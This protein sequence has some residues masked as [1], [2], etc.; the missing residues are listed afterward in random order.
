MFALFNR[1]FWNPTPINYAL[2]LSNLSLCFR[3]LWSA[4]DNQTEKKTI[5][6]VRLSHIFISNLDL[7]CVV[8]VYKIFCNA[9]ITWKFQVYLF[10]ACYCYKPLTFI[11]FILYR[12]KKMGM[13]T[14]LYAPKDDCKH[15]MYWRDLYSVEEAGEYSHI[16]YI[17]FWDAF[18]V[19]LD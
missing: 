7:W 4:M 3:L 12:M 19:H 16:P 15:R 13:N 8:V 9:K 6:K 10:F 14:Y 2:P 1:R 17:D 18:Y 11:T 5:Q